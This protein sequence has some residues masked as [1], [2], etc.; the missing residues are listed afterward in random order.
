M[1]NLEGSSLIFSAQSLLIWTK[2][3]FHYHH[4][5]KIRLT[6]HNWFVINFLCLGKTYIYEKEERNFK[7]TKENC[8]VTQFFFFFCLF[9]L[10][11]SVLSVALPQVH[12]NA[13]FGGLF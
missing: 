2:W 6:E 10:M 9:S 12:S 11:Y 1:I 7:Q 8:N 13:W 3:F 5:K 4:G